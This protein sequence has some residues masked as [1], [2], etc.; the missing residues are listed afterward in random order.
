MTN[1]S[2]E[3]LAEWSAEFLEADADNGSPKVILKSGFTGGE[4]VIIPVNQHTLFNH[5]IP[6]PILMT[7][8]KRKAEGMGFNMN[9]R[10]EYG[11]HYASVGKK[12]SLYLSDYYGENEYQ[13]FWQA[14]HNAVEGGK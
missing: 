12:P 4:L 7:I 10:Y 14:L 1:L 3:E 8:G 13:A 6:S 5:E 11:R 9:Q 2:D